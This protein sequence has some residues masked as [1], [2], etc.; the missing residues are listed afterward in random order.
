[1]INYYTYEIQAFIKAIDALSYTPFLQF[2]FIQ[3]TDLLV[4]FIFV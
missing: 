2:P 3:E 4:V 1:M